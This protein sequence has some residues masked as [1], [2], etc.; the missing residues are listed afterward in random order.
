[1]E[2]MQSL[3]EAQSKRLLALGGNDKQE[4]SGDLAIAHQLAQQMTESEY[5]QLPQ[6][7]NLPVYGENDP[8]SNGFDLPEKEDPGGVMWLKV[9]EAADLNDAQDLLQNSKLTPKGGIRFW[10]PS[11]ME[12]EV[13]AYFWEKQ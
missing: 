12:Y 3:P 4:E 5:K 13:F 2:R 9:H 1:M 7:Q 8:Q 10:E 6:F 11:R